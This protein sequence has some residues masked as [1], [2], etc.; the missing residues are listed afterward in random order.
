M[1]YRSQT[2]IISKHGKPTDPKMG[3][4][5]RGNQSKKRNG[6]VFLFTETDL[7]LFTIVVIAGMASHMTEYF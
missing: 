6:T 3:I 1:E 7:S 2:W 5:I 4:C